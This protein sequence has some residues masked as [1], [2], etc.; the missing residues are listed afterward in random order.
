M[1]LI[2]LLPWL[3]SSVFQVVVR[4]QL[5]QKGSQRVGLILL[6]TMEHVFLRTPR[7]HE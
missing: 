5:H 3:R 2:V 7:H 4:V 1:R 6:R